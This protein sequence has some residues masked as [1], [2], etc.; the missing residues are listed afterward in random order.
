MAGNKICLM[1]V[2]V[3]FVVGITAFTEEAL[4]E[5]EKLDESPASRKAEEDSATA[6]DIEG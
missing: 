6:L 5:L 3:T 2:M 1:V 4:R